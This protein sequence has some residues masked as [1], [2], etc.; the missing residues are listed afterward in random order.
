MD[1]HG[2]AMQPPPF[3]PIDFHRPSAF[4]TVLTEKRKAVDQASED[5]GAPALKRTK[6][7]STVTAMR[8]PAS[9][10]STLCHQRAKESMDQ[11]KSLSEA[12]K[13]KQR[14]K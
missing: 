3:P 14:Y 1:Q 8:L 11:R 12:S 10:Q 7:M 5:E 4:A 2:Q 9:A 13:Q 6:E